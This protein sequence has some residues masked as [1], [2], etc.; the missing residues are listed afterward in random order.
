MVLKTAR[1]SVAKTRLSQ[2]ASVRA[3]KGDGQKTSPLV[4]AIV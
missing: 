2:F 3:E 1:S 4:F